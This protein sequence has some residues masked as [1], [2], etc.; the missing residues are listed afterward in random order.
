MGA[1]SAAEVLAAQTP[2]IC[3]IP[4]HLTVRGLAV[5]VIGWNAFRYVF[6]L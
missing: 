1:K 6:A 4:A 3:N 2:T 5:L